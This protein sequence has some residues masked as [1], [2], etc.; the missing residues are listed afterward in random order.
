MK[1]VV[2]VAMSTQARS[3]DGIVRFNRHR[4]DHDSRKLFAE[5][6]LAADIGS[7]RSLTDQVET[8]RNPDDS[9]RVRGEGEPERAHHVGVTDSDQVGRRHIKLNLSVSSL[10]F[11]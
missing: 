3:C 4:K 2:P 11:R 9:D 6:V 5:L 8:I 1:T 10:L 7:R